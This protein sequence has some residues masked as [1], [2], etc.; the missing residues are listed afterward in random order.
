ERAQVAPEGGARPRTAQ[1]HAGP[2]GG[3]PLRRDRPGPPPYRILPAPD[4]AVSAG[5]GRPVDAADADGKACLQVRALEPVERAICQ[6]DDDA[7]RPAPRDDV[8]VGHLD[9][10]AR[11]QAIAL[12]SA[13]QRGEE[14][15]VHGEAPG[16]RP[17]GVARRH[18]VFALTSAYQVIDM[19]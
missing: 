5:R 10:H 19:R 4:D 15:A 14:V 6:V 8:A 12:Q 18:R 1:G 2:P 11:P 17:D 3:A 7:V 13:V 16:D 9:A